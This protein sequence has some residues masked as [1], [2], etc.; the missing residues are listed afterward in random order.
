MSFALSV[1]I[2][3][4]KVNCSSRRA[5]FLDGHQKEIFGHSTSKVVTS[6]VRAQHDSGRDLLLFSHA[7]INT[8]FLSD[9]QK[10]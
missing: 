10:I 8:P 7:Y 4:L 2:Q 3:R 1:L 5:V 9:Q 6:A